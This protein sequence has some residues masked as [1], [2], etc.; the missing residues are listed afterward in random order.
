MCGDVWRVC[1]Y[2]GHAVWLRELEE[3]GGGRGGDGVNGNKFIEGGRDA[4]EEMNARWS[5]TL[6]NL[7]IA[8]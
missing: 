3:V 1:W 7:G 6:D 4:I 8:G 2:G 5:G